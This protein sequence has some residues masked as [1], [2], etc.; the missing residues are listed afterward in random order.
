MESKQEIELAM[1]MI[2]DLLL[3]SCLEGAMLQEVV[4]PEP[5]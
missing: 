4:N 3:L 5:V 2:W 1:E